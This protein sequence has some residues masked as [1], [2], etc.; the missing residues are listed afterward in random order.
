MEV[1]WVLGRDS[2]GERQM[3]RIGRNKKQKKTRNQK[4]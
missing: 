2:A 3:T 1:S 4:Q